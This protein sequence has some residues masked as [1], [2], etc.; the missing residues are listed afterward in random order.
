[1]WLTARMRKNSRK[2]SH[3]SVYIT[4]LSKLF[5]SSLFLFLFTLLSLHIS[6]EKGHSAKRWL[7]MLSFM[8]H[9]EFL[10]NL[11]IGKPIQR[12]RISISAQ[13]PCPIERFG[14]NNQYSWWVISKSSR[15]HT[16][17][18]SLTNVTSVV[19]SKAMSTKLHSDTW[20]VNQNFLTMM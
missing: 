10:Y 1:M 19:M 4:S 2:H 13:E 16:S 15:V 14:I 20:F 6:P 17:S 18:T 7:L 11:T 5:R 9:L 3:L 12:Q 8:N